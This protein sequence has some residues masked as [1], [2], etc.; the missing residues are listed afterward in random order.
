[1]GGEINTEADAHEQEDHSDAV[2]VDAPPRH[3]A[4]H[5]RAHGGDAERYP[6]GAHRMWN[7]QQ[8]DDENGGGGDAE[9]EDGARDDEEELVGE[10]ERRVEDGHVEL[11]RLV[12]DL[13]SL[14]IKDG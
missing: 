9:V 5:A 11:R 1:V 2:Q 6:E 12:G 14:Y 10:D 8:R 3:V 4:R 7:E 13:T